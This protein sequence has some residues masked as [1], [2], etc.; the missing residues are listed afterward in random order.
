MEYLSLFQRS[1]L[2]TILLLLNRST[3][4]ILFTIYIRDQ[5]EGLIIFLPLTFSRSFD[6]Q[7]KFPLP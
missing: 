7:T 5:I 1:H 2:R 6:A 4:F 3:T